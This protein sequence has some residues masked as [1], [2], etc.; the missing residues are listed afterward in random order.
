MKKNAAVIALVA[1]MVG[2]PVAQAAGDFYV[3]GNIGGSWARDASIGQ[4]GGAASKTMTFNN[5]YLLVAAFDHKFD[6]GFRVESEWSYRKSDDDKY[7]TAAASGDVK[8]TALMVNGVYDFDTGTGWAP[9][10]GL[11]VGMAN[12][13][14]Q[15][16]TLNASGTD[17]AYQILAGVGV[18]LG[19]GV[20]LDLGYRYFDPNKVKMDGVYTSDNSSHDVAV[21]LR[22]TF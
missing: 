20:T 10:L 3:S 15:G 11:G 13:N 18:D 8:T 9:Y 19:S 17:G 16:S 21:G 7:G 2:A 6:G 12:V 1:G 22:F 5:G 14:Y 4:P